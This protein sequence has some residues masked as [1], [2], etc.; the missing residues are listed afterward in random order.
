[1]AADLGTTLR[2]GLAVFLRES[3]REGGQELIQGD[4]GLRG[5]VFGEHG[6]DDHEDAVGQ[7]LRMTGYIENM[8]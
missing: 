1:M 6:G 7:D 8:D 5:E 4:V 3:Q 2:A